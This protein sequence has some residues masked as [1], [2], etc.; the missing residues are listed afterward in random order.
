M[1]SSMSASNQRGSAALIAIFRDLDDPRKMG[2]CSHPLINIVVIAL[3]AV[4]CGAEG[5]DEVEEFGEARKETLLSFLDLTP[6]VPSADTFRRVFERIKPK[7]FFACLVRFVNCLA[8]ETQSADG[9]RHV[10]IDGKTL[11]H[12]FNKAGGLAALHL[13]HAWCVNS[14][15]LIG[16]KSTEAKSNEITA[17]PALLEMLD[18]E[19]AT[20]TIDAMGC[21]RDICKNIIDNGGDYIIALKDNQPTLAADVA[22]AFE[23]LSALAATPENVS[24]SVESNKGHGRIEGRTVTAMSVPPALQEEHDWP[25]LTSLIHVRSVRIIS[26]QRSEESRYY[27]SSQTDDAKRQGPIIR[28]HW[29]VEN[30]L[31]WVQFDCR[32]Q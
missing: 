29:G 3:L 11:R 13:V 30:Q 31:H 28:N 32:S 20:I 8:V 21:Q 1:A 22:Q 7:A 4:L 17:I 9:S 15:L 25:G 10:A 12:S 27:I 6:G 24:Q 5:W 19:D 26:E 2:M 14:Q 23:E 16:Q 18:I